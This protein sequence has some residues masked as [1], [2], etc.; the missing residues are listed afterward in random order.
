[1]TG[2]GGLTILHAP[3]DEPQV[4]CLVDMHVERGRIYYIAD[5]EKYTISKTDEQK[6]KYI[7]ELEESLTQAERKLSRVLDALG[8]D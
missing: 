5:L 6:D 3:G 1:M 8:I 4:K 2:T 7:A